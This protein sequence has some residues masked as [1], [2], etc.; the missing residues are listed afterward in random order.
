MLF[1]YYF[2]CQILGFDGSVAKDVSLL[3]CDVSLGECFGHLEISECPHLQGPSSLRR[4][5]CLT[6]KMKTVQ[7]FKMLGTNFTF[8]VCKEH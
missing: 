5:N 6:L 7:S 4:K 8:L 1:L 3:G 2:P